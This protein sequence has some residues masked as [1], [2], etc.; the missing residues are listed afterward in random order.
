LRALTKAHRYGCWNAIHKT[1]QL[2]TA[3]HYSEEALRP[4]RKDQRL[5]P[6]SRDDL[7]EQIR[8]H[9]VTDAQCLQ[10]LYAPQGRVDL[11]QGEKV[12]L[13]VAMTLKTEAWW[14]RW[15]RQGDRHRHIL[16]RISERMCSLQAFAKTAGIKLAKP[17]KD[18]QTNGYP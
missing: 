8:V 9:P 5:V 12:L 14:A 17:R 16:L 10:L 7:I 6:R 11:D 15:S 13:S 2:E 18:L 3:A 4:D 1:F